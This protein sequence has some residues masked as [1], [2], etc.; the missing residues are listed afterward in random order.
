MSNTYVIAMAIITFFFGLGSSACGP[1]YVH[2]SEVNEETGV[3]VESFVDDR[4]NSEIVYQ[5]VR[6]SLLVL[7]EAQASLPEVVAE[8][9]RRA[10]GERAIFQA[11]LPHQGDAFHFPQNPCINCTEM[12]YVERLDVVWQ[13]AYMFE[14][15]RPTIGR[16]GPVRYRAPSSYL[17]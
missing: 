7:G 10:T 15:D 2:Y 1:R 3:E 16:S 17:R 6:E 9:N 5:M 4:G 14:A 8:F 13:I 12:F 11:R